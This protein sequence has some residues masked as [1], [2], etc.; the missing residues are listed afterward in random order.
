MI[1]SDIIAH[2]GERFRDKAAVITGDTRLT[3]GA[4]RDRV[5]RLANALRGLGLAHG[6]RVGVLSTNRGEY[7]E[8]VFAIAEAGLVWVP[9]N[10]RLTA[11]EVAFIVN[12]AQCAAVIFSS[13]LVGI[14]EPLVAMTPCV[15]EWVAIGQGPAP[16]APYEDL[17]SSARAT[18][19]DQRAF[20]SDLVAIMYT[21]GT[22]G[23]PKGAMITHRQLLSGAAYTALASGAAAPDVSLQVIPQFHAG[24]NLAQVAEILVGATTVVC[25]HFD[26][27][28]VVSLIE[29]E[30]VNFV[31]FVP[32]ML[33]FLLECP[34]LTAERVASMQRVMYGGSAIAPDRLSRALEIFDADFQQVYGQTEACVFATILHGEDHR[35][36]LTSGRSELLL[37]CGRESIGYNVRVVDDADRELPPGE[38]G[39]VAIRGDSVMH[40]YW[41]LPEAS[42]GAL[43]NG[44]LHT[45]DMGRHDADKYLYIVDRKIDLIISGGEN[46]YPVEVENVISAHPD[47]LEVAV[48][49]VPDAAWGEAVKAIVVP[50]ADARLS[51]IDIV[52]FCRDRI[53]RFKTPK[54]ID[55][56]DSLPRTPS[57]KVMKTELRKPYWVGREREV[58]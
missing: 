48:I 6:D 29:A 13:D 49:G 35:A 45:G 15:R 20:D 43:R 27:D 23:R 28:L 36:G 14:A 26:P 18:R 38:V 10:F 39:E 5:L 33:V 21:S 55:F 50:R 52:S 8:C 4:L 46:V 42:A 22:T 41:N 1:L 17:V 44:W 12:D 16:G 9:L 25:P 31:C 2:H 53:A 51:E 30:R 37:S 47:V 11:S 54:S 58:N 57:G 24:G 34:G 7:I 40:G 56:A 19:S 3:Y 32:S